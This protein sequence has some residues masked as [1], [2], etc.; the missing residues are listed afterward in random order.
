M[1]L[2]RILKLLLFILGG[3][4][5]AIAVKLWLA[6]RDQLANWAPA[7]ATV[8]SVRV[9]EVPAQ[10][11]YTLGG[12]TVRYALT[13]SAGG[14]TYS[15]AFAEG[16]WARRSYMRARQDAKEAG[17]RGT[18]KILVD[19]ADPYH[20]SLKPDDAVYYYRDAWQIALLGAVLLGA[21][22]LLHFIH[23]RQAV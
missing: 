5:L 10:L 17:D 21:G 22:V 1:P 12:K 18:M 13:Y 20:L 2:V 4:L 15:G 11:P 3:A 8:D 7:D 9:V 6:D 16:V 23:P 19:P 14:K